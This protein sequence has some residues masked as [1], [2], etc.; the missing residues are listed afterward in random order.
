VLSATHTHHTTAT[1]TPPVYRL[2]DTISDDKKIAL[3]ERF[4]TPP[5]DLEHAVVK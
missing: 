3:Y 4:N 2:Q 5:V 1:P